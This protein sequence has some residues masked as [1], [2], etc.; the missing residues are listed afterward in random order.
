M[1][2]PTPY[3]DPYIE[4]FER[5]G[6]V[7]FDDVFTP[8]EIE[9]MREAFERLEAT[10]RGLRETTMV[11]GSQF[12]VEAEADAA[13]HDVRIQRVVW[14]GG[15]EPILSQ[16]GKDTRLL[17]IA[18]RLL[19]GREFDQLINQ[20]HFKFPG[21]GVQFDWHQ[22]SRH[23]RYGTDLWTD[24]DG[25]GSF[26]ELVTAIDASTRSNGPIQ[27]IPGTHRLGH[28]DCVPGTSLLPEQSFDRAR[29]VA[30]P[31]RPGSVLAFGPFVFHGSRPN[32]SA[33]PR[34][35]FLNGFA[36][37]GANRRVYPGEGAGRRVRLHT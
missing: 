3:I 12:V 36:L 29:A 10:A 17:E 34:R 11:D 8:D 22:D 2:D 33:A 32:L 16:F 18:S 5:D 19:G 15:A 27:F 20:A 9:R 31:M 6:F 37:P 7:V 23:R 30:V 26:I 28:L 24:I 14:C 1:L 35:T 4:R 25:R 13:D 21:D